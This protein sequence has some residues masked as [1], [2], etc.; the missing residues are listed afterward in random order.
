MASAARPSQ[1]LPQRGMNGRTDHIAERHDAN[2]HGDWDRRHAHFD[3]GHFFVFI[4]GFWCGLDDGFF[5]GIIFRIMLTTTI[6]T[7]TTLTLTRTIT[8][9]TQL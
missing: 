9:G 2:W 3:H 7:I 4:N 6:R 5:R 1:T 8:T